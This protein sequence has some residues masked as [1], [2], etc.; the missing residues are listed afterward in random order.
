[1]REVS[2]LRQVQDHTI[3]QLA[4]QLHFGRRSRNKS[5]VCLEGEVATDERAIQATE[6]EPQLPRTALI[7]VSGPGPKTT[8]IEHL[9]LGIF[10][11]PHI[12]LRCAPALHI[13]LD[14]RGHAM[15]KQLSPHVFHP[16]RAIGLFCDAIPFAI[17][18]QG[19]AHFVACSVEKTFQ[20]Y[21]VRLTASFMPLFQFQTLYLLFSCS[22]RF[23]E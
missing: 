18:R 10:G 9:K 20:V 8:E 2:G 15:S 21:N 17:Q 13:S 7:R 19:K 4:Q 5:K 3:Q 14:L 12:L 16:F 22:F 23:S 11:P 1:M 6:R